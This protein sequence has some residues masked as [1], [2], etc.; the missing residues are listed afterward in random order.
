VRVKR[1]PAGA[2]QYLL[3]METVQSPQYL[4]RT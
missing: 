2:E 3:S 1:C 4:W